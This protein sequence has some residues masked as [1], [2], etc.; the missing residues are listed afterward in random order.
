MIEDIFADPRIPH[1]AYRPIFV[2]SL[3]MTPVGE[4][5]PVAAIGAYW[6]DKRKFTDRE[7]MAVKTLS[8]LVGRALAE[9]L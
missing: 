5:F 9:A 1:D 2:K 8:L 7:V 4:D 6:R 3:I